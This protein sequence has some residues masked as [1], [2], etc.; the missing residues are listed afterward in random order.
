[1]PDDWLQRLPRV[2]EAPDE[3]LI[4][5]FSSREA[6]GGAL[7]QRAAELEQ[8]ARQLRHLAAAIHRQTVQTE[9]LKTL[10]QPETKIDLLRGALLVAHLDNPDLEIDGYGQQVAD[11]ANEIRGRLSP[12]AGDQAKLDS[13][14]QYLF[15]ENGFH[16]SRGDYYNRA[17]SYLN[18]V[19]DDREGLPIT[20]S[21]LFLKLAEALEI[22]GVT[23]LPLPGHFM[24]RYRAPSGED[25]IIDVHGGGQVL[26]RTQAQERVFEVTGEGFRD[27]D[28]RSATKR[29]II[30]RML[31][32]LLGLSERGE[33]GP[34]PLRYL[35]LIV[36][37]VPDSVS[38]RLARASL[39]L[40][41]GDTAGA[42]VDFKWILDQQPG[43]IDLE[44]IAEVYR[45][46]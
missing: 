33:N 1:L 16:G 4:K 35:D 14:R 45:T 23:G 24:V 2:G 28:Y 3:T 12:G 10:E 40:Q 25:Q 41:S 34:D 22:S 15:A 20:L 43:G 21:I 37:L 26:T 46:L 32:N 13:I 17:N 5:E 11:M 42:K 29:E 18:Q 38:D 30:V 9:L 7:S 8:Q 6:A 31:R 36:A 27:I 19:I 44:R 39:R